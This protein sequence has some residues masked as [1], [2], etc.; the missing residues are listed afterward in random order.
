MNFFTGPAA[1]GAD[2]IILYFNDLWMQYGGRNFTPWA[3]YDGGTDQNFCLGI[4]NSTA[5]FPTGLSTAR[6]TKELLGSPTT[7]TIPAKG[8]K[9]L[10]YGSL[11]AP[12]ENNIL[13]EGITAVEAEA[14]AL[15]CIKS[16]AW[17]FPADPAFKTLKRTES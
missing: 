6:R 2:D 15:S 5:G 9:T 8:S 7:V 13:D 10:R 16:G 1:A 3:L 4:E 12:Y 17:R 11:F 14:D